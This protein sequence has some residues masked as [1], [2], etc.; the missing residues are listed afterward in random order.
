MPAI[1]SMSY[2][3]HDGISNVY[4]GIGYSYNS[5]ERYRGIESWYATSAEGWR[6]LHAFSACGNPL[7]RTYYRPS[8]H[9]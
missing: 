4:A 3:G 7:M 9:Y 6:I 5:V 8:Q 2:V 1:E